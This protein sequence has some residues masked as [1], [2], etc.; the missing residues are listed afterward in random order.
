M[1]PGKLFNY[2]IQPDN[3][4]LFGSEMKAMF[5]YPGIKKEIDPAGI[6][7]LFTLWV[8]IPPKT[9]FKNINELPAGHLLKISRN[10]IEKVQY[11]KLSYP[12]ANGYE[13]R[14]LKYYTENINE[15]LFNAVTRR[16]R[17]DVPVASYLSG[18]IDSS[19]ISALVKKYHN[20]DLITFS[21]AFT[22]KD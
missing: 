15:L 12:D 7:Q 16:L 19:V 22:E 13:E 9:P 5:T 3:T 18:G 1:F 10:H 21:V 17:A 6:N 11:W 4:V 20:N 14:P 8:N 2:S